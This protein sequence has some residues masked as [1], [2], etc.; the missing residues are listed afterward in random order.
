MDSFT[1]ADRE[2]EIQISRD[3]QTIRREM[4]TRL[5]A[6]DKG[7]RRIMRR[8]RT[9]VA[10]GAITE[11]IGAAIKGKALLLIALGVMIGAALGGAS[12]GVVL[13]LV[14]LLIGGK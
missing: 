6:L 12:S 8:Q 1:D 13:K 9:V 5:D 10:T 14:T 2:R 4:L 7:Q 3:V 11:A